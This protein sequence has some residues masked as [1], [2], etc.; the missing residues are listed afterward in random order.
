MYV[1]HKR[2]LLYVSRKIVLGGRRVGLLV[3]FYVVEPVM[4]TASF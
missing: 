2:K 1:L 3:V 4:L